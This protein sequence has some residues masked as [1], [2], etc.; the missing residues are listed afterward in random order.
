MW[1]SFC[2]YD[3][4]RY[5]INDRKNRNGEEE[6]EEIKDSFLDR[7]CLKKLKN[8]IEMKFDRLKFWI[9]VKVFKLD[10]YQIGSK[11][12]DNNQMTGYYYDY[13]YG[14]GGLYLKVGVAGR[15]KDIELDVL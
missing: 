10:H 3:I 9:K 12:N 14:A 13:K 2:L 15:L 8:F 4:R 1:I 6:I 11:K 5:K 7:L